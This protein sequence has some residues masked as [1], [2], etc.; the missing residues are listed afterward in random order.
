[1]VWG[2]GGGILAV[3]RVRSLF[4]ILG[5]ILIWTVLPGM[6]RTL[7][8]FRD[9]LRLYLCEEGQVQGMAPSTPAFRGLEFWKRWMKRLQTESKN[10]GLTVKFPLCSG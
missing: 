10:T 7:Q 4:H 1:M 2:V 3:L 6:E 9:I 5:E 8:I